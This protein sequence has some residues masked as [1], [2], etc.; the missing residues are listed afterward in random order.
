MRVDEAVS[1][2]T[3]ELPTSRVAPRRYGEE[4]PTSEKPDDDSDVTRR[5]PHLSISQDVLSP[6]TMAVPMVRLPP[7]AVKTGGK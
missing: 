7:Q 1:D 5:R 6:T 3:G 2:T 4:P